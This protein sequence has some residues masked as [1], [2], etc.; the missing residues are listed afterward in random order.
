MQR[1][2]KVVI[3]GLV[4]AVIALSALSIASF[5]NQV[6]IPFEGG[7]SAF[8]SIA[9]YGPDAQTPLAS[10]TFPNFTST[11]TKEEVLFVNST[12]SDTEVQVIYNV[13]ASGW[14]YISSPY[15]HYT[16][17]SDILEVWLYNDSGLGSSHDMQA[18][19]QICILATSGSLA[20]CE[21]WLVL[22]CAQLTP[23]QEPFT[24]NFYG[25]GTTS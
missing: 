17:P 9:V 11:G 8:G 13:T 16:D 25:Y 14:I 18:N 3:L 2:I 6:N 7:V 22:K 10:Y 1:K 21:F 19:S 23:C 4:L 20:G 5:L 24:V 15:P 12:T